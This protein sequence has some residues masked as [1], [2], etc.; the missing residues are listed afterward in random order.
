MVLPTRLN[1]KISLLF[2]FPV[3]FTAGV[4]VTCQP[5]VVEWK[6]ASSWYFII[7]VFPVLTFLHGN[8]ANTNLPGTVTLSKGQFASEGNGSGNIRGVW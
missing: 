6:Q 3:P 8:P 2:V 1:S 7:M 5:G 4:S